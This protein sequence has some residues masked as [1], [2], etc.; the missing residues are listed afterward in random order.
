MKSILITGGNGLI[1]KT[2]SRKLVEKGYR[3]SI[4]SRSH[5]DI[6]GIK[7]YTWNWEKQ[8]IEK[9]AVENADIIIHL[10]GENVGTG[11]WTKTRKKQIIESRVKTAGL[12]LEQIKK[13]GKKPEAFISSSAT[14]YYGSVTTNKIFSEEDSPANDFLGKVCQ[15]WERA[16]DEFQTMGIRTVKIRS[17]VVLSSK[18]GALP[19]MAGP[20]KSGFGAGLGNGKQYILWIH[21]DDLCEIYIKAIEDNTM[22]GAYNA[23]ASSHITNKELTMQ[24]AGVLKKPLWLPNVPAF[25]MKVMFGEMSRIILEGSRISNEK[26]LNTGFRFQYPEIEKA[27]EDIF[28]N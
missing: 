11:R 14:G 25:I 28:E 20:I 17:G 3:V 4:L 15:S 6:T 5:Q 8:E 12:L 24:I 9:G 21:M 10:A 13:T 19:K 27:L 1:G 23:V 26:L 22:K 16:S 2:L 7:S 18:G